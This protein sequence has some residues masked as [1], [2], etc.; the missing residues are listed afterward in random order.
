MTETEFQLL[1]ERTLAGIETA[2]DEL[3]LD[4]ERK[5]D[6]VLELSFDDDSRIVVN[7][8]AAAREIWVAAKSGGQHFRYV[9]DAWINTRDGGELQRALSAVVSQQ[10]GRSVTLRV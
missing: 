5:A 9:E 8:Q 10:C 4:Y 3:D 6:T 7:G 1:V 2:L